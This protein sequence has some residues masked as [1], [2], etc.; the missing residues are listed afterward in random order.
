[1]RLVVAKSSL[2]HLKVQDLIYEP[3]AG[4]IVG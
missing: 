2:L 3:L 1:M 4:D